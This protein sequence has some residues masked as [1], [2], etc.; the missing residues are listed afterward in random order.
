MRVRRRHAVA[1]GAAHALADGA[2]HALADGAAHALASCQLICRCRHEP[3]QRL[4][5]ERPAGDG[6]RRDRHRD[7][8]HFQ[9]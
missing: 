1:D 9:W 8:R 3:R 4:S 7:D 2:A 6:R 5:H